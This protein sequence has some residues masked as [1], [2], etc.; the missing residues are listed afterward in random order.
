MLSYTIGSQ[1]SKDGQKTAVRRCK[2]EAPFLAG[3]ARY[4]YAFEGPS[5]PD[6]DGEVDSRD[7]AASVVRSRWCCPS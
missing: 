7:V 5:G 4:S 1:S 6:A 3:A 2:L